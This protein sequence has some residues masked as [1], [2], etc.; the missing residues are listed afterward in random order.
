MTVASEDRT[1]NEAWA[2]SIF[3]PAQLPDARLN[4][5]LINIV[6]ALSAQ[7]GDNFGRACVNSAAAKGAYRFIENER[8]EVETLELP[9]AQA[10]ARACAGKKVILA[11][12]DTSTFN[13]D[14]LPQTTGLGPIGDSGSKSQGLLC[15]TTLSIE[16]NGH[17]LGVLHQE[18]W[19][20]DREERHKAETRKQRA[21]EEKESHK[22]LNG[23]R[24]ARK[25]LQ[26]Q[27]PCAA[28]RPRLVHVGDREEDSYEVF[29][30]IIEAK[31]G[32]VI[33]CRHNRTTNDPL[34]WAYDAVRASPLLGTHN[35][36]VPRK[37]NQP[38]RSALVEIRAC[39]LT[40]TPDP[41][42]YPQR[43]ALR[44]T[45]VEVWE[46][47]PPTGIEA[48]HWRLWT[49]E[50]ATTYEQA[51]AI[52][53]IYKCRWRI[54]EVHL[55][56]KSGCRLEAAQFETAERLSKLIT[57]CTPI[58]VR[59]VALRDSA[60]LHPNAVCT[61]VLS[62]IEWCALWTFL[63]K[64]PPAQDQP[65]PTLRQAILWIGRLG[66]HLGRKGDGLPGI[67]TLWRGFRDLER[68]TRT[69]QACQPAG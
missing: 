39:P 25:V 64:R 5:R 49:T 24:S 38:K 21:I 10:T 23:I 1:S 6:A 4:I 62:A 69:F 36:D 63:N 22:W 56:M 45:L 43:K 34:K 54:E 53:A 26:A 41:A 50:A 68:I 27:I 66:G 29:Q 16:P 67:R 3:S 11:V 12:Q 13:Y 42:H 47:N 14:N 20:R 7:P 59:I 8:V 30:E 65:P 31:E 48:L 17:P 55:A 40:L 51:L 28:E 37:E 35:L 58:A 15:H 2:A 18:I 61:E 33:R 19:A 52:V 9:I 32:A 46:P 60:R 44:L 57:L